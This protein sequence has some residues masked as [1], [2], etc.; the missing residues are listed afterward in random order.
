M[1]ECMGAQ[2]RVTGQWGIEF[3]RWGMVTGVQ[4]GGGVVGDGVKRSGV[5]DGGGSWCMKGKILV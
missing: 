3:G 1:Y 2:Q 4:S 5:E